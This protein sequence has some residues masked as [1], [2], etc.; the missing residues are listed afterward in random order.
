MRKKQPDLGRLGRMME[1][2]VLVNHRP[3]R[4]NLK[5]WMDFLSSPNCI[6][7]ST[8]IGRANV[9]TASLGIDF[10]S[11]SYGP[12]M[13]FVTMIF[14]GQYDGIVDY[15]PNMGWGGVGTRGTLRDAEG[16]RFA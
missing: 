16:G 1:C 9:T 7:A 14:G 8:D 6:V 13:A 11:T 3:T 10:S 12:P 15:T 4:A 5:E 2:Y